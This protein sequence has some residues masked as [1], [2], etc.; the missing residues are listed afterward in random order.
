MLNIELR[1]G[2]SVQIGKDVTVTLVEKSGA[3]ARLAFVADKS[4]PIHRIRHSDHSQA[5][6]AAMGGITG[7]P[8]PA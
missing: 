1:P 7:E 4:I 2:E 8:A 6:V 5:R 3:R